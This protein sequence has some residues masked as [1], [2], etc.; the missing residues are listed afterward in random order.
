MRD[1]DRETTTRH[2]AEKEFEP[3]VSAIEPW[4]DREEKFAEL[5]EDIQKRIKRGAWMLAVL[6]DVLSPFRRRSMAQE[7]DIQAH[8][9][10]APERDALWKKSR[11]VAE[12][13]LIASDIALAKRTMAD[14][15]MQEKNLRGL[16]KKEASLTATLQRKAQSLGLGWPD[17]WADSAALRNGRS[18]DCKP[19]AILPEATIR[20]AIAW[21]YSDAITRNSK[22]PN[23]KEIAPA[24]LARLKT[25]GFTTTA[26]R[27]VSIAQEPQF[28][29]QRGKVG[30]RV[31]S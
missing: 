13:E 28:K 5:P 9:G 18:D 17:D 24:A 19:A 11:E 21:V 10:L 6:W 23:I 15:K 26:N 29:A 27:I 7:R 31:T 3:L 4:F 12:C 8:P 20:D 14:V 30:K 22:L 16:R 1:A 2:L 25:L